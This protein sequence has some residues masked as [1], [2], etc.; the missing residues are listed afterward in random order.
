MMSVYVI[1]VCIMFVRNKEDLSFIPFHCIRSRK[2]T[3]N[4]KLE[5]GTE[6]ETENGLETEN[7]FRVE[8]SDF[9]RNALDQN[10]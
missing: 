1:S 2:W 10:V 8:L 9:H 3:R 5:T 6:L 4:E 7:E